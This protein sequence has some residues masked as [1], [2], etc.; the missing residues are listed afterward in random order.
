MTRHVA[1]VLLAV[2]CIACNG[3]QFAEGQMMFR[4]LLKLRDEVAREFK[5]EVVDI[6]IANGDHMTVKFVNSPLRTRSSGEKQQRAD[7]VA[8]FVAKTY[9]K[10]LASVSTQFVT[11]SGGSFASMSMA[12][13]YTGR[14]PETR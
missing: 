12:E 3:E 2:L 13:T 8:A 9:R 10:P 7:A 4:E 14:K 5:E 6:T 1:L 11:K